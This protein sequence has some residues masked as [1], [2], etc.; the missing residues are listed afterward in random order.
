VASKKDVISS[1][2]FSKKQYPDVVAMANKIAKKQ[3]RAAHDAVAMLILDA[4]AKALA[5]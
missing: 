3:K 5:K 2:F 1:L 4:G